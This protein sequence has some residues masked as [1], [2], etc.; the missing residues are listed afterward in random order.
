MY[1]IN[2]ACHSFPPDVMAPQPQTRKLS[3]CGFLSGTDDHG[4]ITGGD[5]RHLPAVCLLGD[6]SVPLPPPPPQQQQQQHEDRPG[7]ILAM[8]VTF[9][10]SQP[11]KA[12]K[13]IPCRVP[14]A[15]PP[16]EAQ[17]R[18]MVAWSHGRIIPSN[19]QFF[20]APLLKCTLGSLEVQRNRN[21][22]TRSA[23]CAS[24]HGHMVMDIHH[25]R[26]VS[27]GETRWHTAH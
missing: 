25:R 16:Q 23:A 24:I 7:W 19:T 17:T 4:Q 10:V 5:T 11:E 6:S 26:T 20:V 15:Q 18:T 14:P 1:S 13:Y 2:S 9:W 8:R 3:V 12:P 21:I 27:Q 22:A